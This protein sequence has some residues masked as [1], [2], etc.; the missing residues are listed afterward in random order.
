[1]PELGRIAGPLKAFIEAVIGRRLDYHALYPA[2]VASQAANGDLAIVPDDER[3][4]GFGLDPVPIKTGI[5]GTTVTVA[6]GARVLLG[7]EAADPKRPYAALWE[8]GG[9]LTLTINANTID[10]AAAVAAV[11]R[12]G[13]IISITGVFPAA[14]L[15]TL[16]NGVIT[17][18]DNTFPLS[19]GISDVKA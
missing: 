11:I 9:L 3:V 2:T 6:V 12:D 19:G 10:L 16:S 1:M 13:E 8:P 15:G 14:G 7:F 17:V 5:P 18:S 4:R